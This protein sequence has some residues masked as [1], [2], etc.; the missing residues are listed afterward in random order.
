MDHCISCAEISTSFGP[1]D[2]NVRKIFRFEGMSN[3][4]DSSILYAIE[5]LTGVKGLLV[6]G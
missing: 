3:P 4:S 5:T 2:F 6:D 1:D